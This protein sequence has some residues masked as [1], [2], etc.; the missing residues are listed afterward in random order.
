MSVV[1]VLLFQK[2]DLSVEQPTVVAP[3]M[4]APGA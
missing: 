4:P 2:P 1:A 3:T